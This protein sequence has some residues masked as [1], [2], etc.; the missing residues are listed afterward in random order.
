MANNTD[1]TK[2]AHDMQRYR[3]MIIY[4]ER[5]KDRAV[6]KENYSKL[7]EI[8]DALAKIVPSTI[9][10]SDKEVQEKINAIYDKA[11][12]LRNRIMA[13]KAD[14]IIENMN[15]KKNLI[16]KLNAIEASREKKVDLLSQWA[17]D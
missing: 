12:D 17:G 5:N 10:V 6:V 13:V 8:D 11:T 7:N 4:A 14:S 3:A 15:K 9:D 1:L 2:Y 16:N